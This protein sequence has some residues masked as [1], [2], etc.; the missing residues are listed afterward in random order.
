MDLVD[1]LEGIPHLEISVIDGPVI[2]DKG[3]K[4]LQGRL[5]D[6]TVVSGPWVVVSHDSGGSHGV[7]TTVL[8]PV[9]PIAFARD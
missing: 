9:G 6:G 5:S 2:A 8:K 1:G 4:N 3:A 7:S